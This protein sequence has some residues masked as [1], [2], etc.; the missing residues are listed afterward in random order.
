MAKDPF[1]AALAGFRRWAKTT[2]QK[3]SGD[4]GADA[5]QLETLLDLMRDYLG[6]E[7]PAGGGPG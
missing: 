4:P 7:C 6:S 1:N 3:L 2:K 5:D